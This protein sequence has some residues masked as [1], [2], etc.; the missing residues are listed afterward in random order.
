MSTDFD[1]D[2]ALSELGL[3]VDSVEVELA[4]ESLELLPDELSDELS[5]D[6]LAAGLDVAA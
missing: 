6:P 5:D 2:E 4:E 3:G 1:G